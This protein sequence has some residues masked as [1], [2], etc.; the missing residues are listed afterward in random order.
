M[1]VGVDGDVILYQ[2][3]FAREARGYIAYDEEGTPVAFSKFKKNV[4]D[5]PT[6]KPY[7]SVEIEDVEYACNIFNSKVASIIR[8]TGATSNTIYLTGKDN[9]RHDLYDGYKSSRG[10][11]PLLYS[12]VREHAEGI[13]TTIVSDGEEADDL[14]GIAQCKDVDNHIIATIDKDL[15]M[16]TGN[17]YNITTEVKSYI[18]SKEGTL[19]FYRQIL[20]GDKVDDIEGIKGIGPKKA[21]KI[22]EGIDCEKELWLTVVNE[23]CKFLGHDSVLDTVIRN[24]RLLWIRTK[25]DEIWSPPVNLLD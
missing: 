25:E 10:P 17:H 18:T 11:K 15:L 12:V 6:V 8:K 21:N 14:L 2:A 19:N 7:S 5:Y 9:F 4:K 1:H 13:L 24:A 23:W 20:T 22:L 3:A 16:I